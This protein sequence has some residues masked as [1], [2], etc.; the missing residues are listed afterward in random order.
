[1][2]VRAGGI[3]PDKA[4]VRFL[5]ARFGL[6]V[7]SQ[8]AE[9]SP[10]T[11]GAMGTIW[12]LATG[13]GQTF[14]LKELLWGGDEGQVRREV[15][16]QEAAAGL[17]DAPVNYR[18]VDDSYICELP[19]HLGS[20]SV[21]LFDW[22][23]GRTVRSDDP[24]CATWLGHAL[25]GL[26]ALHHPVNGAPA[27]PWYE[28]CPDDG[29]WRALIRAGMAQ[30]ARWAWALQSVRHKLGELAGY[31]VAAD[32][33]RMIFCHLD[34]QPTN[35]LTHRTAYGRSFTLL[36]WENAGPATAERELAATLLTWHVKH[37]NLD[38]AG[39]LETLI[40]YRA[41]GGPV[42]SLSREAF[43]MPIAA[44][45]NY[46]D[47]QAT[48][49]LDTAQPHGRR[50][51]AEQELMRSLANPPEVVVVSTLLTATNRLLA[52]VV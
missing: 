11:R 38:E 13:T 27:D 15:A 4:T 12:R 45:L 43:S 7:D 51:H 40:A 37:G 20:A 33:Q 22:V 41:A 10:V 47:S 18:S 16:F 46:L 50:A 23:T 25:G 5:A 42:G 17:V 28:T 19:G 35:V 3:R 30:G 24:G 34:I 8:A 21:R 49:A 9:L 48:V 32:R 39:L 26:H 6:T 31:V 29:Y 44:Y 14:A 36:D 52:T 2:M 1:M